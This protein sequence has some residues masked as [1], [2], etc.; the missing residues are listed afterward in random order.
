VAAEA[1]SIGDGAH[2]G[3][4]LTGGTENSRRSTCWLGKKKLANK[5]RIGSVDA[6]R[7]SRWTSGETTNS[8]ATHH[9]ETMARFVPGQGLC[10]RGAQIVCFRSRGPNEQTDRCWRDDAVR[11]WGIGGRVLAARSLG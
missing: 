11:A 4:S 7:T 3:E 1:P 10:R 2:L 6:R 9:A 5:R 8:R